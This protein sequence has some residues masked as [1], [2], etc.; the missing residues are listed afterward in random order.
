MSRRES[1]S[2]RM[3]LS[4]RKTPIAGVIFE[5]GTAV[6]YRTGDWRME[7]KPLINQEKCI[8]CLICWIICPDVSINRLQKPYGKYEE[9]LEVD[10][11]HCKGCGICS[12][13]CPVKAIEMVEESRVV[14]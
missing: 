8:R 2:E 9:T 7:K 14:A 1:L 3:K 12:A 11:Y 10:Y 5:P 4:W 13:E 6:E